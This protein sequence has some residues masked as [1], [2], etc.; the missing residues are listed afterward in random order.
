MSFVVIQCTL[1]TLVNLLQQ[2][3]LFITLN[4]WLTTHTTTYNICNSFFVVV[5][6]F[7]NKVSNLFRSIS[8][9]HTCF[10]NFVL[11]F[12][13]KFRFC[14][15]FALFFLQNIEII[16]YIQFYHV[17]YH[18]TRIHDSSLTQ[19][20]LNK[21]LNCSTKNTKTKTTLYF[22]ISNNILQNKIKKI[23]KMMN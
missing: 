12:V 3:T 5:I 1:C 21:I 6:D 4:F 15:D 19:F 13:N 22:F 11:N 17:I 8:T 20:H 14:S 2:P 18:I 9:K 10:Q 7:Y 23:S 16:F